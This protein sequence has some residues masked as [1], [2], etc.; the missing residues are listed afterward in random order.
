MEHQSNTVVGLDIGTT[1][2]ACFVGQ[3]APGG[4]INILGYGRAASKGVERGVVRN[5][6][7]TAESISKA[8]SQASDMAGIDIK[9]VYVGIAG[10]HIKSISST[11]AIM[12]PSDHKYIE[13][14]DVDR[15]TEE[16]RN[17]LLNPGEEIIHILAQR[18]IVDGDPLPTELDPVGVG[19]HQLAADFHIVTGN[20]TNIRNIYESVGIAGLQVLGVVLEPIASS[21][22]VLSEIDRLAGVAL[23]DIGGGTTDIAIFHEGIIRH[24][25]VLPL[26]GNAITSDIYENCNVLKEQAEK[27]KVKFGS[28]LPEAVNPNDIVTIPGI[29]KPSHLEISMPLLAQIIQARTKDI[30]DQ[31]K[32]EIVQSGYDHRLVAGI[33]LTGGGAKLQNIRELAEYVTATETHIGTPDT[34]L[35]NTSD[36]NL[37]H[38][39]YATGIGLVIYALNH[40]PASSEPI[41]DTETD[42]PT[43]QPE[44]PQPQTPQAPP[45]TPQDTPATPQHS[46]GTPQQQ[47][48][49]TQNPDPDIIEI[50]TKKT[51]P[52]GG[53]K[54][55]NWMNDVQKWLERNI[56]TPI[57][58]TEDDDDDL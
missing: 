11:G 56:F 27:L 12:I 42:T 33:V 5:I 3:R 36:P 13:Q 45:D 44:P 28:C 2:I 14:E 15:L 30:L 4:K 25:S 6:K 55:R 49:S 22:A 35:A 26:A 51:T 40:M 29:H 46:Q 37:S 58:R 23:V 7:F 34:H 20:A 9:E 21:Q 1:K 19:G 50:P 57:D 31:V 54:T 8:V 52:D 47:Q 41:P 24:T 32:F 18:Y 10:Q 53:T 43:S 39:M 16:Q 38:P 17:I 48:T